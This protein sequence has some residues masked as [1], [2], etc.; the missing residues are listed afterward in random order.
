MRRKTWRKIILIYFQKY[1][2]LDIKEK[3]KDKKIT[4]YVFIA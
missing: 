2:Y 4:K 1:Y 3:H